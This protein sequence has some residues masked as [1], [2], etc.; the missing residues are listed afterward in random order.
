MYQPSRRSSSSRDAATASELG[1]TALGWFVLLD[2]VAT[3]LMYGY[4]AISEPPSTQRGQIFMY[5]QGIAAL[6]A[7]SLALWGVIWLLCIAFAEDVI[8]G[9]LC[10][11]VPFYSL[12]FSLSRWN[13]R[14]GAF[15]LILAPL[16]MVLVTLIIGAAA[17][18][19][20]KVNEALYGPLLATNEPDPNAPVT[21][22]VPAGDP[23]PSGSWFGGG[24][25]K[26]VKA[27]AASV[28]L[29]EDAVRANVAAIR[30]VTN[31]SSKIRDV[32]SIRA[33]LGNVVFSAR[34]AEVVD[35]RADFVKVGKNEMVALKHSV[36]AEMRAAL[37]ELKQEIMRISVL[38]EVPGHIRD[39]AIA[40]IDKAIDKWT[41]KPGEE[42]APTLVEESTPFDSMTPN[43]SVSI[44]PGRRANMLD[45]LRANYHDLREEYGDRVVAIVISGMPGHADTGRGVTNR[46]VTAA[47]TRRL[48]EL[49][50]EA[51]RSPMFGG[52]D[53][54]SIVMA[55][56]NDAQG[57]VARIDFGTVTLNGDRIEVQL[58]PRYVE[59]VPR[60][61]PESRPAPEIASR[62]SR[63]RPSDP[64]VPVGADTITK[65][66]IELKS[67]EVHKKKQA[68]D[69]LQR[70]TPDGRAD[71]VVQ[72]LIPLLEDDD[73]FLVNDAIKALAIWRSPEAVSSLIARTRDNR[74]FVRSEAI[75]ALG[76]YHN[77]Q[78]AEAIVAVFKEDGF[79]VEAALKEMGPEAE[80]AVISL[81]RNPDP[82]LRRKACEVLKFIGGQ[83]TLQAMQSLPTDSDFGVRVS[84]QEAWKAIVS[85]VGPPPKPARS[86]KSGSGNAPRQ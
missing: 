46:D 3:L 70:A 58:D 67:S 73:A 17:V 47:V 20:K 24:G 31:S 76:K 16:A 15:G 4:F 57:L 49:A 81:L 77:R 13:E 60:L 72:A 40:Q 84:A 10:I 6:G 51:V 61:A 39:N 55:P 2:A 63:S 80:P 35:N 44:G 28:R 18:G 37:A 12:F 8:Q 41:I 45:G 21:P 9:I 65:S 36:G 1:V 78:A 26:T 11:I 19:V 29:A 53:Q 86:T 71:Q 33:N 54:I 66:L 62:E 38:M 32:E 83:E 14:R 43:S 27:N 25:A 74:H 85:R 56:V 5:C 69:R 7:I 48:K 52:N 50:P 64:E 30:Q 75:K 82:G 34:M 79:A 22:A 68:L 23:K 42:M 59:A